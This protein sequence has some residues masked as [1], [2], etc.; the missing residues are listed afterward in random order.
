MPIVYLTSADDER[1]APYRDLTSKS[2]RRAGQFVVEGELLI[3]RLAES[4]FPVESVLVSQRHVHRLSDSLSTVANVYVVAPEE[5]SRIVG[6]RFHRG[7]LACG[8]R[9]PSPTLDEALCAIDGALRLVVCPDLKDPTN[10]GSIVR[11]AAAFG[12]DAILLGPTC[13]DPFSRRV[14]RVSMGA[15]FRLSVIETADLRR[16]LVRLPEDFDVQRIAAVLDPQAERLSELPP[17]PRRALL[18]GSEGYG[19]DRSWIECCDRQVTIPMQ[20]G[21]DSLNVAVAA[22]IFLHEFCQAP[23]D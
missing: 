6:F 7:M 13:A 10:L 12:A 3:G 9:L 4:R 8:R 19:L 22:G 21:I 18:L 2:M 14:M 20:P 1:L 5:I 23:R 16:D 17:A 11:T 15:P